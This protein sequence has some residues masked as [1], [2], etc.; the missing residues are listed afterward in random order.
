MKT[1]KKL[2]LLM[3]VA[4]QMIAVCFAHSATVKNSGENKYKA[5]R[6]TPEIYANAKENLGDIRIIDA[7]GRA[8]PYFINSKTVSQQSELQSY[9]LELVDAY[10]KDDNYY[11]DYKATQTEGQDIIATALRFETQN[12]NFAKQ[13]Q[14]FGSHDN[15]NWTP[16]QEDSIY[17]VQDSE[18]LVI[19]FAGQQ[20]YT[21]YRLKLGNNLEQIAF[22]KAELEYSLYAVEQNYF[23]QQLNP[24]FSVKQNGKTTIVEI[25]GVDKLKLNSIEI[26]TDSFF[27]RQVRIFGSS[28]TLHNLELNGQVYRDLVFELDGNR[29][30]VGVLALLIENQDDQPINVQGI[31]VTYLADELVFEGRGDCTVE[32]GDATLFTPGYDIETYKEQILKDPIDR[33]EITGVEIVMPEPEP[34]PYDYQWVFN[35]VIIGVG[36]VLGIVIVVSVAKKPKS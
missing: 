31:S 28:Q 13:V 21:H 5:V 16:I 4:A 3:L 6:L 12:T 17:K 14:V 10:V 18:K 25:S 27:K 24:E 29:A 2:V 20:K 7:D 9:P 15:K 23:V 35:L 32:F 11:F 30:G 33:L 34:E 36:A 26:V 19:N 1:F 22:S 8:V